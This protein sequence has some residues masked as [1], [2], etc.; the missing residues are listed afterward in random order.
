MSRKQN[1]KDSSGFIFDLQS[2]TVL[3]QGG[4]F[5]NMKEKINAVRAIVP[6]K[7][8]NEIILVLQHFDNCVDKTVQAFMEGSASEVLK[9]WT[10]TGKKKNKKKKSKPKPAVE[11]SNSIPDSSKL[12]SIQEERSEPSSEKGDI[13]GYHVN[14]AIN[15]TESVDSLSEGV[16]TLSI[17]ARELEDPESTMPDMLDRTGSLLANGVSDFESKSLTMHPPQNSQQNRNAAK[18]LSRSQFSNLDMEDVPLSSTNKKLGSNIEKSVKDLQRCTVSLARYRVVVKE[19]MDASIK[20]MKQAFADL[21]SCLM[22]REVALLAEMD[23]VK[24]EAM[25]ILLSRQKKAE[26]LKKM[27]DVAVRMSEEQLV[28]LRADIKH[29]VSERKYDEDLGRVARFTCDIETLKK[30]IDSFGQVSHPKNSYSTRSRCSSVTSVSLSSLCDAS[31][32]SFS[33]C[34]SA[35]SL[36]STNKKNSAPGETPEGIANSS[37]RSY[38]PHREVLPGNRRGQGYRPQGQKFSD[39]TNQGRHNSV[40]RHRN[41]S[42]YSS[43]SR[44]QS[45]P[46]QA[47]G[48]TSDW[49]QAHSAGTNGTGASMEPGPPKPSF[50]RGSLP[51]RK[52]RT[53]HPE[54]VNS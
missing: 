29:F 52:P 50:K 31:A 54:A 4:A 46:P 24:A 18:S 15:D 47:P 32:A 3:A 13:N 38:Q 12:V 14:G 26:L 39:P 34:A 36:T 51:Q 37:G 21:Q 8:N 41:S 49:G 33:T 44:Y 16:E 22:D 25:E 19:E 42:W 17:D 35:P 48:N 1:Q 7:S 9:E 45:A 30:N 20:K 43:G 53:S 40:G 27:T 2:N 28:E 10:V 23:K 6:N 11:A 5:E